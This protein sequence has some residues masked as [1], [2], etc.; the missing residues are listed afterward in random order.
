MWYSGEH[1]IEG[2]SHSPEKRLSKGMALAMDAS[3]L[4]KE[5]KLAAGDEE[6]DFIQMA[7]SAPSHKHEDYKEG[8]KQIAEIL[9]V[10]GDSNAVHDHYEKLVTE[11]KSDT[12][13]EEEME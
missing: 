4:W 7:F 8:D 9:K 3:E 5:I 10:K 12:E 6:G 11:G 13:I 2:T 1:M